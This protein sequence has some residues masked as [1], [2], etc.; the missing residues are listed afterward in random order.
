MNFRTFLSLPK[1]IQA[2]GTTQLVECL[3]SIHKALKR[4]LL[5][6]K[7]T[8]KKREGRGGE[9][10]EGGKILYSLAISHKSLFPRTRQPLL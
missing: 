1:E 4:E 5:R 6:R 7:T 3:P 2:G 8:K 10:M 9:R